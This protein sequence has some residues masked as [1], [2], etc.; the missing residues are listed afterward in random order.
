[1]TDY[2]IKLKHL[3]LVAI[4]IV[5][6]FFLGKLVSIIGWFWL[7]VTIGGISAGSFLLWWGFPK[8]SSTE[9]GTRSDKDKEEKESTPPTVTLEYGELDEIDKICYSALEENVDYLIVDGMYVRVLYVS[10]YPDQAFSNWLGNLINFDGDVDISMHFEPVESGQALEDLKRKITELETQ[11]RQAVEKGRLIGPEIKHPLESSEELRD[12]I[13]RRESNLF[14]L[15]LYIAITA[16]DLAELEHTTLALRNAL[17]TQQFYAKTAYYQQIPGFDSVLPRADNQLKMRRN[18]DSA[19]AATTFPFVS[20]ELADENGILYGVNQA[21]NSLVIFDRFSLPNY[22]S[23]ILARTGSGKSYA[24]KLEILRYLMLGTRVIVIDPEGEYR[25]LCEAVNGA[26]IELGINS[27]HRINPFDVPKFEEKD[28]ED[29]FAGHIETLTGLLILMTGGEATPSERASL[30]QALEITYEAWGVQSSGKAEILKKDKAP[31]LANIYQVLNKELGEKDLAKRLRK[32][33]D[34]HLSGLFDKPTNVD[35]ENRLVVF[36]I[37]KLEDKDQI[38]PIIM[39]MIANFVWHKIEEYPGS[40]KLLV[41][42]EAWRLLSHTES[43]RFI[44]GLV[45]RARKRWLGTTVISQHV[46]DFAEG[47]FGE[48]VLSQSATKLLFK[49]DDTAL[50]KVKEVFRLS[51]EERNVIQA[52][53]P[54]EAVLI[55]DENHVSLKIEASIDEHPLITTDPRERWE[56]D[57]RKA[58]LEKRKAKS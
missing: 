54:G 25:H 12:K 33:V 42:D 44:S 47:K 30:E 22:N 3:V 45:R 29:N 46:D 41:I 49:Q 4:V 57:R 24:A 28:K 20:S 1:M 16:T 36:N 43:A 48:I 17:K 21:N 50:E 39:F 31:L 58:D 15:S 53:I 55:A 34:G 56:L 10:G 19:S 51:D 26:Y 32:Y 13:A 23:I 11:H 38:L 5:I 35:L 40:K 52:G 37:Q 14:N 6:A 27:K 9:N 18:L 8:S 7:L 2:P